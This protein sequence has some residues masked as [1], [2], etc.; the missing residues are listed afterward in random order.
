[1]FEVLNRIE[2]GET[3]DGMTKD[4]IDFSHLRYALPFRRVPS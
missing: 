3:V 1:M 2:R 4:D